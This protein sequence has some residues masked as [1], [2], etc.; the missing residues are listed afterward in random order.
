MTLDAEYDRKY[1]KPRPYDAGT[2]ADIADT[3]LG[4]QLWEFLSLPETIIRMQTATFL[5]RPAVEP[6]A[7]LLVAKFG[8]SIRGDRWKQLIGHMARQVMER[9]GYR[10]DAQGI[11]IRRGG[12]FS[13]GSRYAPV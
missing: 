9:H 12:L 7:P 2:F 3:K 10:L 5:E 8:D 6:L 1:G 13:S 11:R 4:R